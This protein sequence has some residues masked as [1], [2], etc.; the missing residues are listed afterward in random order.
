[1]IS[2]AITTGYRLIVPSFRVSSMM[3]IESAVMRII[4]ERSWVFMRR[5]PAGRSEW[6]I[7]L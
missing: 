3:M 7:Y 2:R 1:M 5:D 4:K 6:T